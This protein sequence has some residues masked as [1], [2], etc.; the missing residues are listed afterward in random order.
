MITSDFTIIGGGVVGL[1]AAL[2]MKQRYSDASVLI[3]E[4]EERCG[5]HA[6]G[7]NS[8]VLHA[9]FYYDADSLKARFV[10]EGNRLMKE[11]CEE[12]K[13]PLNR[14]G[15]LVVA[16]SEA[17][18]AGLDELLRRGNANGVRLMEVTEAEAREIEPRARTHV[19]ALYSPD[20]ATVDPHTVVAEMAAE[21]ERR[22]IRI[23]TGARYLARAGKALR[24]SAGEIGTGYTVNAAGLY[25][26]RIA[27]DF[28]FGLDYRIVPFKGLYL[29]S[30]GSPGEFRA[31]IYPV[32][33]LGNPFLGVHITV[34]HA[35]QA[36][37]GPTA[38]PCLWRE[39]YGGLQGFSASEAADVGAGLLGL[40]RSGGT[41]FVRLA[42]GE[43]RKHSRRTL[44]A[45]AARLATGIEATA[46]RRWGEP[47][48]RAQL[49]RRGD[50]RLVMDFCL[51]G[52]EQSLHIL[53]AV[54]PAFTCARAFAAYVA[55]EI[56]ARTTAA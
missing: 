43:I 42:A 13:L 8:G 53:N 48:I 54:S 26:D 17:D 21:S 25:A 23:L 40:L 44:A 1:A 52:D 36:K 24:T 28:G 47:G 39:Q 51:E 9:G 55:S 12:R 41:G 38:I 19:R 16:R 32:P 6:S 34:G 31:C 49:V 45:Q 10:R 35:G 2:E 11:F 14:C 46:F 20:T 30:S 18:F 37:I 7:R 5:L 22:G 4:K 15:K 27:R 3:I 50:R 56:E 29:Y 33:D